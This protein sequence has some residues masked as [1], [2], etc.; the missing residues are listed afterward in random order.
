MSLSISRKHAICVFIAIASASFALAC[1]TP[2]VQ[3][4]KRATGLGFE[5]I[6]IEGTAFR[7][8]V[9]TRD[10]SPRAD[11]VHVYIGGDGSP[12]QAARHDPPDPTP[13]D[14]ITLDLMAL[15]RAP[16]LMLGRPCY[17]DT[18]PCNPID[19][20]LGRYSGRVVTSMIEALEGFR[21]QRQ[22]GSHVEWVL[23]GF[24]GGGTL[25]VLMAERLGATRAI[26][27]LAGNLDIDAWAAHHGYAPLRDSLNPSEHAPLPGHVRQ[28]HLR[29]GRDTNVLPAFARGFLDNQPKATE[30]EH[31][32]FDHVC[33][34]DE[35]WPETLHALGIALSR[36]R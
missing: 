34:W 9:F 10:I 35:V 26:V 5:S 14:D 3:F 25:A 24:S 2:S 23:I 32:D 31:A 21:E 20:S 11:R 1:A 36:D 19:F 27:T 18:G 13:D 7:H 28:V 8:A 33:C 4:E 17:H 29:G 16:R 12:A 22:L 15:D 30:I 6:V